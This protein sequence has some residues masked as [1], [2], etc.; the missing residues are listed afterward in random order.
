M[1]RQIII[2]GIKYIFFKPSTDSEFKS[3][4]DLELN[5]HGQGALE[6]CRAVDEGLPGMKRD[7]WYAIIEGA[8]EPG[9]SP[10]LSAL[11]LMPGFWTFS[12]NKTSIRIP[13]AELGLVATAP[14]ARGKGLCSW[15]MN[16]YHAEVRSQGFIISTIEGIPYFYRRFG[17]EYALPLCMQLRLGPALSPWRDEYATGAAVERP[18]RLSETQFQIKGLPPCRK[19]GPQ[20]AAILARFFD[21]ENQRLDIRMDR[22]GTHWHYLLDKAQLSTD[23]AVDRW[24]VEKNKEPS[25][26]FGT[27]PDGFGPGLTI[28]EAAGTNLSAC[29][30]LALAD[31]MRAKFG[32]PHLTIELP[33]SHP[34]SVEAQRLGAVY[35]SQY[36]WQVR[37][38]DPSGL[39]SALAPVLA[40]RLRNSRFQGKPYSVEISSYSERFRVIWDGKTV[41]TGTVP[42]SETIRPEE[43]EAESHNIGGQCSLSIPPDLFA[44]LMLGYRSISTIRHCRHDLSAYGEAEEFFT[45]AFPPA[46]GFIYPWF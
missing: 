24:I 35:R 16:Q 9:K 38:M 40:E 13:A 29:E 27:Q 4:L 32:R 19:A 30:T 45:I 44:P 15:L 17:Y 37:V 22:D 12:H 31:A 6:L 46:D 42:K 36:G 3:I 2:N 1:H 10:V 14:E 26:Y 28:A 5:V 18:G 21:E 43:A 8:G 7:N 33:R 20:D 25:G 23:T 34:V 11:C 39:M 41:S